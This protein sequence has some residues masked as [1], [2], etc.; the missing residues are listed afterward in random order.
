MKRLIFAITSL[1]LFF[2]VAG[3]VTADT[4]MYGDDDGFGI[5]ATTYANPIAD[6]AGI[7]EAS[8]TDVRLIG[9]G[10]TA[11]P[12]EP[13]AT[14]SFAPIGN[15]NSIEITMSMA[16]FGGNISPV[17]GPNSI[18][19]DGMAVPDAFLDSFSSFDNG[20]DPNIETV[21]YM[22]PSAFFPLFADGDLGLT[23]THISERSGYT[24]FQI[25]YIRFDVDTNP[26]PEPASLML[27][28]TGLGVLGLVAYRRRNK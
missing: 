21:S 28:G 20:A 2:G 26:I 8:G 11:P 6:N 5:G 1:V 10:Y 9:T 15:I 17:D 13:T 18:V 3:Q 25:D 14:L 23:G 7:G 12:F 16:E 24:S 27:L 22:L 4:I 19:L